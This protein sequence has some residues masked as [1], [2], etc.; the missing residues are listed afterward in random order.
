MRA[1]EGKRRRESGT[2]AGVGERIS[3]YSVCTGASDGAGALVSAG[4]ED[5]KEAAPEIAGP[6]LAV[7][8]SMA[9]LR[10][11]AK[12]SLQSASCTCKLRPRD[13]QATQRGLAHGSALGTCFVADLI[14]PTSALCSLTGKDERQSRSGLPL[15]APEPKMTSKTWSSTLRAHADLGLPAGPPHPSALPPIPSLLHPMRACAQLE[16]PK[17]RRPASSRNSF[18]LASTTLLC[19]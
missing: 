3:F 17:T 18:V 6:H 10:E 7:P 15:P 14:H 19:R 2:I 4:N 16:E 8:Q 11:S 12:G 1:R 9:S 13:S 5:E